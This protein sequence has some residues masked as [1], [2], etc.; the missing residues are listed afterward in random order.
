MLLWRQQEHKAAY[1]ASRVCELHLLLTHLSFYIVTCVTW[2][3]RTQKGALCHLTVTPCLNHIQV[4]CL[5]YKMHDL[6]VWL[7]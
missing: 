2:F 7:N 4:L 1:I 3:F 5:Y 6:A